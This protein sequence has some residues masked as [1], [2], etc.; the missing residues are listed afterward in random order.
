MSEQQAYKIGYLESAIE[1]SIRD[2]KQVIGY[3]DDS[4]QT[5]KSRVNMVI[6][7][8]SDALQATGPIIRTPEG[9]IRN[10]EGTI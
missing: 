5:A 10:L 8:M 7:R 3:I 4:P 9:T 1:G 6:D 2:L